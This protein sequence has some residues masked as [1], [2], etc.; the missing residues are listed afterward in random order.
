MATATMTTPVDE[1]VDASSAIKTARRR[2]LSLGKTQV[3][4]EHNTLG[5]SKN[6]ADDAFGGTRTIDVSP[7]FCRDFMRNHV[8][9][10][11]RFL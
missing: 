7:S 4:H 2:K 6:F 9:F 11:C 3:F 10:Y 8:D 1:I 5:L